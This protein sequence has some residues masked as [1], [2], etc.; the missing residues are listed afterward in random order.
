MGTHSE[1]SWC[2]EYQELAH[3]SPELTKVASSLLTLPYNH[4][5]VKSVY[6]PPL[7]SR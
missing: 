2:S 1:N 5:T 3:F 6:M 4:S 7:G